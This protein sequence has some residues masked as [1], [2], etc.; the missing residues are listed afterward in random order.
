[1]DNGARHLRIELRERLVRRQRTGS[2]VAFEDQRPGGPQVLALEIQ[3]GGPGG[4]I[5]PRLLR[6]ALDPRR[7]ADIRRAAGCM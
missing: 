2:I 5:R 3:A 1:M 4:S 6:L 7:G